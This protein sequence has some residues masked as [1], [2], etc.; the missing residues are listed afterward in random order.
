MAIPQDDQ[1]FEEK[2]PII[3][4]EMLETDGEIPLIN[5]EMLA[6]A[7]NSSEEPLD[8]ERGMSYF[9]PLTLMLMTIN[10]VVFMGQVATGALDS[11]EAII[12][13]GAL[14]RGHLLQGELWRLFSPMFLHGSFDHLLG[15]CIS[16]YVLGIACE[17]ALGFRRAALVYGFSGLCASLLSVMVQPGPSVGASGAIFGLMAFIV[18]FLYKNQ[19]SF[20]IR[21]RRI[22][23]VVGIWGL[24]TIFT[25]FLTPYVDNFAHIGGAIGGG[26]MSLWQRSN[27]LL[28]VPKR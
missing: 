18:A 3:S 25:G 1:D 4:P 26:L 15:N 27:R 5:A 10:T 16:L 11:K 23:F 13:A 19:K 20:F 2:P 7:A 24:Y 12:A 28:P 6:H 22:G 8:F 21:D 14:E 9:P 17:H